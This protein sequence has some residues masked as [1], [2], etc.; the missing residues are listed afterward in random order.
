MIQTNISMV[1]IYCTN[2]ISD[3]EKISIDFH[4][5]IS[6]LE[7][8][9]ISLLSDPQRRRGSA[10]IL[11]CTRD[12]SRQRL[13]ENH[14][15]S[16][17]RRVCTPIHS[18]QCISFFFFMGLR[19]SGAERNKRGIDESVTRRCKVFDIEVGMGMKGMVRGGTS[20]LWNQ[21]RSTA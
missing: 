3:V 16:E 13:I 7:Y 2:N 11:H 1:K 4:F 10:W 14:H 18:A 15:R 17:Y 12:W 20:A 19:K 8:R 6:S 5:E 21:I 9:P